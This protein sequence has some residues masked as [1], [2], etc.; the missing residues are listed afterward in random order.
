MMYVDIELLSGMYIDAII[1]D[2]SGR[3]VKNLFSD[4]VKAGKHQL[5]FNKLALSSGNYVLQVKSEST[6]LINEKIIVQR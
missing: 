2:M 5:G 4:Y 3:E 6:I 1:Y